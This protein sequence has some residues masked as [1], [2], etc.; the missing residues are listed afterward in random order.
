MD[1]AYKQSKKQREH[2]SPS[3]FSAFATQTSLE[4]T[5]PQ[6]AT[7]KQPA[8]NNFWEA[9]LFWC[10]RFWV[11]QSEGLQDSDVENQS[12]S[13][14][15]CGGAA[16]GREGTT[17]ELHLRKFQQNKKEQLKFRGVFKRME[18]YNIC[19]SIRTFDFCWTSAKQLKK[20][21]GMKTALRGSGFPSVKG[22]IAASFANMVLCTLPKTNIENQRLETILS[23]WGGPYFQG[24]TVSLKGR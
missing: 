2:P 20:N 5:K 3:W 6:G 24:R 9:M 19:F 11:L 14:Q 15:V 10:E 12:S 21:Q 13:V 23:F 18:N 16:D 8:S 7:C 17:R 22:G 4:S 1:Q